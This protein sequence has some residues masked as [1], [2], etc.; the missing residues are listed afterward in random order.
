M[1]GAIEQALVDRVEAANGVG[2]LGYRLRTVASY[3]N[4]LD[5]DVDRVIKAFPAVWVTYLGEH[6]PLDIGG[7]AWRA[8]ARFAVLVAASNRRNE[9]AT[10]HGASGEPGAYQIVEDLRTLLCGED[11]GLDA[12]EVVQPAGVEPRANGKFG[13]AHMAV[14]ALLLE[15][16][17]VIEPASAPAHALGSFETFHADWDLPPRGN[18][19]PPLPAADPDAS[20]T[21]T[22]PQDEE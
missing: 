5:D 14:Y 9:R 17:Y 2:G 1:I 21:V 4:E 3:G 12:A 19:T 13:A 15:I 8:A 7:G 20:D 18:V 6:A 10:R 22:L 11:L 16:I